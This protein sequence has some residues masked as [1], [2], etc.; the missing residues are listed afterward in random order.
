MAPGSDP[1]FHLRRRAAAGAAPAVLGAAGR[2]PGAGHE[3]GLPGARRRPGPPALG[4]PARRQTRYRA[5]GG[6][7]PRPRTAWAVPLRATTA[8]AARRPPVRRAVDP[9][10]GILRPAR[11][12]LG[13]PLQRTAGHGPR[14]A[15][16]A[17][18]GWRPAGDRA[19]RPR[20]DRH[21]ALGGT[22]PGG[23]YSLSHAWLLR[24]AGV[25]R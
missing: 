9:R 17:G 16:G 1:G 10:R 24:R 18:A 23:L 12:R 19:D 4:R 13:A 20:C 5:A 25:D 14:R 21:P 22:A 6:V 15:N 3:R 8:P 11:P 2:T 7:R